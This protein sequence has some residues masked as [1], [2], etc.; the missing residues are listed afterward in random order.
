ME[1]GL[2]GMRKMGDTAPNSGAIEFFHLFLKFSLLS[3]DFVI[4]RLNS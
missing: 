2:M 3:I 4:C 1:P